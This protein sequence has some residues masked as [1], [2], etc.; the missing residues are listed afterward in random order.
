MEECNLKCQSY[1]ISSVG[2]AL[3]SSFDAII[4]VACSHW[5]EVD[6][7]RVVVRPKT[8]VLSC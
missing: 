3:L 5:N 6:L 1:L 4:G 7:A 8:V 2:I